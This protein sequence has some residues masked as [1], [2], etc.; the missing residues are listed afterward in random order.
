M[1]FRFQQ[2]GR[3][4]EIDDQIVEWAEAYQSS[5][6]DVHE[7]TNL[8]AALTAF[9]WK[10]NEFAVEI[11]A[12]LGRTTVFMAK[13]LGRLGKVVSIL[14]IDPFERFQPNSLNPQGDYFAY[15]ANIVANHVENV[16][17]P[18]AAFSFHAADVIADN[19]GVLVIDGDHSYSSASKDLRLF[20]PKVRPG[21]FIFIDDYGS[22]YPGVVQAVDEFLAE[23]PNFILHAKNYFVVVERTE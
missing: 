11:G 15:V 7:L 16:C 21:G 1:E 12:Y 5:M 10:D 18:L 3:T 13:V 22:A 2:S 20:A 17:L 19:V 14:S 6:L 8:A 23:N 4:V 9:P